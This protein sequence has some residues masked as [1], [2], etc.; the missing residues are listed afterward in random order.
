M[1]NT[2]DKELLDQYLRG[3][4]SS[5]EQLNLEKRLATDISLANQLAELDEVQQGIRLAR[6]ASVLGEVQLGVGWFTFQSSELAMHEKLFEEYFEPYPVIGIKRGSEDIESLKVEA[7]NYYSNRNYKKAIP[8]LKR[9]QEEYNDSLSLYYYGIALLGDRQFE[10]A[11]KSLELV[12]EQIPNLEI[13]ANWY[14]FLGHV[15]KGDVANAT[16][17]VDQFDLG[18]K[19]NKA[20]TILGKHTMR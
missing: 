19:T 12:K 4:L 9:L 13:Q 7:L 8:L 18:N 5:I 16:K 3:E 14:I 6:L 1:D 17:L 11:I 10:D 20:K 2:N 15:G